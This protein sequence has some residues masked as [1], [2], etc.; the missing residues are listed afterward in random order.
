MSKYNRNLEFAWS[1]RQSKL[2]EMQTNDLT[3]IKSIILKS[4]YL[5]FIY[6]IYFIVNFLRNV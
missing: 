4:I 1:E 5:N 3:T 2:L 6:F